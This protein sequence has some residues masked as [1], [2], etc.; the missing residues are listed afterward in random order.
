MEYLTPIIVATIAAIGGFLGNKMSHVSKKTENKNTEMD[1][2]LKNYQAMY[3]R[4]NEENKELR[5][6]LKQ[7]KKDNELERSRLVQTITENNKQIEDLK[8]R[9]SFLKEELRKL[10]KEE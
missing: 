10:N 8:L 5:D 3:D 2:V 4:L 9:I 7:V 1:T 6:R